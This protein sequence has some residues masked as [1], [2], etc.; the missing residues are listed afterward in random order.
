MNYTKQS[1]FSGKKAV[2]QRFILLSMYW[3]SV[4]Q[5]L[6]SFLI[7]CG[8]LE[9]SRYDGRIVPLQ[10]QHIESL[11]HITHRDRE[12]NR[13]SCSRNEKEIL[14]DRRR[15]CCCRREREPYLHRSG[16]RT[17]QYIVPGRN[18]PVSNRNF[19]VSGDKWSWYSVWSASPAGV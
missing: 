9:R 3:F 11:G 6:I 10:L 13:L 15:S 14:A 7:P 5:N 17:G 18:V 1:K 4:H 16:C 8:L 12:A 2:T 19:F